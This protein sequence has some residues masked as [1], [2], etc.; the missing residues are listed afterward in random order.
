MKPVITAILELVLWLSFVLNTACMTCAPDGSG[1]MESSDHLTLRRYNA[2]SVDCENVAEIG[3]LGGFFPCPRRNGSSFE[4]S[5][6]IS[7]CDL[8]AETAAHLAVERVN[9]DSDIL[10]NITLI[11]KLYPIYVPSRRESQAVSTQHE[12]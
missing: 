9:Q 8:L 11:Q 10:P 4:A 2:E 7:E 12:F 6:S 3:F 1:T 5:K